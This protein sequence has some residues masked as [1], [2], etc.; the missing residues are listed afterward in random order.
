[1]KPFSWQDMWIP[2]NHPVE[3]A[4][5]SV[6]VY[7][8]LILAFRLAG[9]KEFGRYSNTDIILLFLV[10]VCFR[11][12]IISDDPSITTAM[13]AMGTLLLLSWLINKLSRKHDR[14][15]DWIAGPRIR[16]IENGH[17]DRLA[18][19]RSRL[20]IEELMSLLR[21]HG[22]NDLAEVRAAFMERDGKVTFLFQERVKKS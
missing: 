7:F 9:R 19:R 16:L 8:I 11:K 6:L 10:T 3:T 5:R 20:S 13:L 15:A 14:I 1:M 2:Q 22:S 4:L 17:L 12:S 18:L 21:S